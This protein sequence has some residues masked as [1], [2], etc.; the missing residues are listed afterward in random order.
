MDDE[1]NP[2]VGLTCSSVP[3]VIC[4]SNA[5]SAKNPTTCTSPGGQSLAGDAEIVVTHCREVDFA[6]LTGREA[7]S[8]VVAPVLHRSGHLRRQRLSHG[9]VPLSRTE[10]V[11][12]HRWCDR[13]VF[14]PSHSRGRPALQYL[15]SKPSIAGTFLLVSFRLFRL[16]FCFFPKSITLVKVK[17]QK[18]RKLLGGPPKLESQLGESPNSQNVLVKT[19]AIERSLSCHVLLLVSGAT[20]C[21][22]GRTCPK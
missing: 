13:Q 2:S 17:T 5:E 1:W 9:T 19:L 7:F 15:A 14:S 6:D 10:L 4:P 21:N 22:I 12:M 18:G 11:A 3:V 20:T 8:C 16:F